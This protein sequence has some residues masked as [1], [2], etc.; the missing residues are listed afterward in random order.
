MEIT[1][2]TLESSTE[3][4]DRPLRGCVVHLHSADDAWIVACLPR[5]QL[6]GCDYT[7]LMRFRRW[8]G[9]HRAS[10]GSAGREA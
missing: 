10:S 6:R 9:D 4:L 3:L 5:F 7:R 2:G 8:H 1:M